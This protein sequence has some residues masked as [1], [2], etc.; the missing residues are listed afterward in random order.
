MNSMNTKKAR[1][2]KASEPKDGFRIDPVRAKAMRERR[3]WTQYDLS[4][5]WGRPTPTISA[6]ENK[7][8]NPRTG[9]LVRLAVALAAEIDH[10]S[11]V[12]GY[13]VG[14]LDSPKR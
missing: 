14:L 6:L 7:G 8:I 2:K 4:V 1:G 5:R 13:L 11:D 3:G 10:P 12:L 9:S